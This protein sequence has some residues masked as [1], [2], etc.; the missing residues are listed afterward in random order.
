MRFCW[1]WSYLDTI[2]TITNSR[3]R[4][5]TF[6]SN[7]RSR[8]PPCQN[9]LNGSKTLPSKP[10]ILSRSCT[11]STPEF[12]CNASQPTIPPVPKSTQLSKNQIRLH[13]KVSLYACQS[14]PQ[15]GKLVTGR[16]PDHSQIS[17]KWQKHFVLQLCHWPIQQ[18][19]MKL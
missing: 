14:S 15:R 11:T 6:Q 16:P 13:P 12:L 17:K 9:Y 3:I 2:P 7:G 10:T 18:Y 5:K 8:Q 1:C 19:L 4:E